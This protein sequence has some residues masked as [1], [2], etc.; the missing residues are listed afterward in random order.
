[1]ALIKNEIISKAKSTDLKSF[2]ENE[3]FTFVKESENTYRCKEEHTLVL[4]YKFDSPIYFWYSKGQKG[5]IINFVMSNIPNKNNFR[6]A[7]DYILKNGINKTSTT[8]YCREK[9]VENKSISI[10]IKYS[11]DDMKRVYAYLCKTRG[12]NA[13]IVKELIDKGLL[14]KDYRH[15]AL[16]LHKNE[17]NKV[18][19]A[20]KLGTNSTIRF[21]GVVTGSNQAYG[22]SLKLGVSN[23]LKSLLI[24]EAPMDLLSYY[25]MNKDN[26]EN[27]LLLCT[28]GSGKINI[29]QTYLKIYSIE[30]IYFCMDNDN[31][32][33]EAYGN[34]KKQYENYNIVEG[35]QKL[36]N[37]NVKD[38]N[39]LLLKK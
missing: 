12:I 23:E 32:G 26:L 22:F 21:K 15:N 11:V 19:G 18:V 3:G 34:I 10:D 2:L 20:D 6:M 4:T 30:N 9:H 13:S 35:R 24:F 16:F 8:S 25:Q 31:C 37:A 1:M 28:G 29:I 14:G 7:I 39:D 33:N 38:W 36:L 17:N 27:C 5:D